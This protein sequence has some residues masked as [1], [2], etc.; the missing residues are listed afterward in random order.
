MGKKRIAILNMR[1]DNNYGG[2]LQRYAMVTILQRMGYDVEYLYI[3]DCWDD[4]FVKR[5]KV[6]IIKQ[7]LKQ[8]IRHILHP[9]SEPWFAWKHESD[10]Y[11][12]SSRITE[13]FLKKYIPHTKIIYLHRE[14]EK[15]F[16]NGNYDAIIAGSDQ[17]WRKKFVERYGLGTWFLDFVPEDYKGKRVIYGASF[18]VEKKEY[19]DD[20]CAMVKPLFGR[21]D[22]VSVRENSGLQLLKEYGWNKPEAQVVLDP[23]LLLGKE[24]YNAVIDVAETKSMEGDMFC[25]ILDRTPEIEEKIRAIAEEK[26]LKPYIMSIN[27]DEHVSIEQW[28]RY[29][30][31]AKYVFTDSY[32]GL[33]FTMIY[34]K[35]FH[36]VYNGFRGNAR[37]ESVLDMLHVNIEQPNYKEIVKQIEINKKA[38]LA[39]LQSA[40]QENRI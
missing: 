11:R 17:I 32:H 27:G 25:Y 16:K 10:I 2:N 13:P 26:G 6:K 7:T 22:A 19:T 30:R 14:L 24:D 4:W 29:I 9:S 20:D 28:L 38:S 23:T 31:D 18:G 1:Y 15:V 40:L 5:T 12:K 36:L 21:L 8:V 35:P 3:R 39:F 34:G 33:L 37:F